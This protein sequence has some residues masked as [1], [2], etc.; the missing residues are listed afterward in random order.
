MT[1][2]INHRYGATVYP[3]MYSD[4]LSTPYVQHVRTY[5][6]YVGDSACRY[7]AISTIV[8][9][10]MHQKLLAFLHHNLV[11]LI[12]LLLRAS[13]ILSL[14]SPMITY[15]YLVL[16]IKLY[17]LLLIQEYTWFYE[18]G[19]MKHALKQCLSLVRRWNSYINNQYF[20]T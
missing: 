17:Y 12:N 13:G 7:M 2:I 8:Q 19:P 11:G 6:G 3:Q 10:F 14:K 1:I 15:I 16:L 5:G 18:D 4:M 20:A 9:S